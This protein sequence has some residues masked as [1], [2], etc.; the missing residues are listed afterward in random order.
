VSGGVYHQILSQDTSQKI[1]GLII[2]IENYKNK[3]NS[4][5]C[6]LLKASCAHN[7]ESPDFSFYLD[8]SMNPSMIVDSN[9]IKTSLD[10]VSNVSF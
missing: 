1:W 8:E 3:I 2:G 5:Y 9:Q 6:I 4:Q 7:Y 10:R